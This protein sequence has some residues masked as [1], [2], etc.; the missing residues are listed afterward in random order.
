MYIVGIDVAKRSHEAIV[1]DDN[2]STVR[3]AFNFKNDA[4]GFRKLLS[5]L[6]SVS[7]EPKDFVI[8]M[9]S[10]SHYWLAL[11]SN[12]TKS[13]YT[14]HVFNPI[15]SNALRDMYIRQAKTD[16]RDCFVIAEV[17]RFGRYS[18]GGMPP[19]DIYALREMCRARF[20]MVDMTSDLKR[21]VIALLDQV[22]PEYETL[23]TDIFGLT[24]SA[25]LRACPTP[26]EIL[27]VDTEKLIEIISVPSHKRFGRQKAEQ[28]RSAAQN[29]FG[30][31]LGGNAISGLIKQYM[32]HIRFSQQQIT[33]LDE[34][35]A[36][37]FSKFDTPITT[38]PGVGPVLGAAIFSE[39]GDIS[40]FRS[41]AKLA[42]FAGI[43]PSVKRS[44]EFS[45][46]RNH[47]SK[48]G[49]P[50]LRRALWQASVVAALHDP[51]LRAF[52]QKKR[53]Q[54]K[55]Y[56]NAI[57]HVTRKMASIIFAVLRDNSPYYIPVLN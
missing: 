23:F 28:I 46:I 51:A 11:Y 48:R 22:F 27:A 7:T 44:G 5:V 38:V 40:K 26:E 18:Q 47:M 39:I 31:S 16:E 50:Y 41:A 53:T 54:G 49:S 33:E 35:I 25:L 21:K 34:K 15:Q 17:I 4:E 1:I 42:A 6:D 24:S 45:G 10:T 32:E 36:A 29:S 14:V 2:G 13:S 30:V 9:E 37:L 56:M 55:S 8:G 57:G 3:K 20:F 19:A 52:F 12:L 43:D